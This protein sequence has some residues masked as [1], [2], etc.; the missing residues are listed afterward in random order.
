MYGF[1]EGYGVNKELLQDLVMFKTINHD[2]FKTFKEY[3][4]EKKEDQNASSFWWGESF[5][6]SITSLIK[7]S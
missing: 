4:E 5:K 2:E 3:I 6:R 7:S 1:Y